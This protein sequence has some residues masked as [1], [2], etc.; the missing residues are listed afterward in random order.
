MWEFIIHTC[1]ISG[2]L[3]SC[4]RVYQE[5]M[6]LLHT[7]LP[8]PIKFPLRSPPSPEPLSICNRSFQVQIKKTLGDV[9]MCSTNMLKCHKVFPPLNIL[10]INHSTRPTF[11]A[12]LQP[13]G[14]PRPYFLLLFCFCSFQIYYLMFTLSLKVLKS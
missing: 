3:A 2:Q 12:V 11:P 4:G 6:L 13:I 10:F 1:G 14:E 5:K 8:Q 7:R 9:C